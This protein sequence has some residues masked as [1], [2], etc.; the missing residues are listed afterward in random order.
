MSE[1]NQRDPLPENFKS[2][3]EFWEFWDTHSSADYEDLME[4]VDVQID[5][6]RSKRYYPVAKDLITQLKAQARQQGVSTETLIN[7]WLKE[8]IMET[9]RRKQKAA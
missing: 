2:L 8:K 5:L 7:L 3:E 1:N 9:A 4:D 6:S